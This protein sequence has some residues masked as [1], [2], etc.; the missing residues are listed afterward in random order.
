M[1]YVVVRT[2]ILKVVATK[3][4]RDLQAGIK[5]GFSPQKKGLMFSQKACILPKLR[6]NGS[7]C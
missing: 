2:A 6:S 1:Y 3:S 7:E 5:Q 4:K